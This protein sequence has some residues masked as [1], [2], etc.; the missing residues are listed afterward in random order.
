MFSSQWVPNL[1]TLETENIHVRYMITG[2]KYFNVK[3]EKGNYLPSLPIDK[4]C[5]FWWGKGLTLRFTISLRTMFLSENLAITVDS[6]SP[7]L[8]LCLL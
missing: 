1:T 6:A 2:Y 4:S 5:S 3:D 7:L 8:K